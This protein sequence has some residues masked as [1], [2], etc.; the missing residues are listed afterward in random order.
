VSSSASKKQH[1]RFQPVGRWIR[2][3]KRQAIYERDSYRCLICEKDLR[4]AVSATRTLDH[5]IPRKHNGSNEAW[6][7][8]TCCQSCN[9]RRSAQPLSA[10]PIG[11]QRRILRRRVKDLLRDEP[12]VLE[13]LPNL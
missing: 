1:T 11:I 8:F 2:L 7:L 6:N 5:V 9:S 4:E 12:Y 13:E 10:L 3:E